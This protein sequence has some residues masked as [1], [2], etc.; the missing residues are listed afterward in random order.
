MEGGG[1]APERRAATEAD[2]RAARQD[3]LARSHSVVSGKVQEHVAPLF[4]ES[5]YNPGDA[6]FLGSRVDD[7]VFDGLDDGGP[8]RE[9]LVSP[10]GFEP[11]TKGLKVPCS[12]AELRAPRKLYPFGRS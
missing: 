12:T 11:R 6:R 8:L 10:L 1:L 2:L 4:P 7:V 5:E 9:S 3:S